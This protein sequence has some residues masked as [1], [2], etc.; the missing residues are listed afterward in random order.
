[1]IR[2]SRYLFTAAL[3]A[4]SGYLIAGETATQAPKMMPSIERGAPAPAEQ[5]VKTTPAPAMKV[6]PMWIWGPDSTKS[7]TLKKEFKGGTKAILRASCDN[8]M[9]V[10]INGDEVGTSSEWAEPLILDIT[11]QLKPENNIIEV[12]VGNAGGI[13][14]F[15]G[16]IHVTDASGVTEIVSDETWVLGTNAK[17]GKTSYAKK[18]ANYGAQP[19]GNVL[20][21]EANA[22]PSANTGMFNVLPGFQVEKLF[23]VPKDKFG[24]WVCMT[25][26]N[27][28][29][30]IA[31][32]QGGLG[33][34]RITPPKVG[35][36][37]ET[38]VEKLDVKMTSAQGLL[39][40]FDSLYVVANGGPG[41]GLYR[42]KDTNNDDQFDE[43]VKLKAFAGGGE[44][45]PH[46]VRLTP[47]GKN[48]FVLAGNHTLP[49]E[50][51]NASRLPSNWSEDHLLPRQ[52]DANGHA[53][54]ILAPGGWVAKT[55]PEGKTWEIFTGGYRNPYDFAINGDGEMFVYDADME[56]DIG[57]PWY[58]PT[59]VNHATSGS[60]LGWRSGTG[61]WPAYYVDSLPAAVDIGP[62][63]PV[64]VEF[65]YGTKFPAKYQK[66]LYILDWTFGTIYAIHTEP[67][68]STY[69][70]TKEE[71]VS[72]TPLPLTDCAVGPDGNFYFTVGGR[73]TQSEL[74][75]VIY[76]GKE[77][78][79]KVDNKNTKLADQRAIRKQLESYHEKVSDPAKAVEFALPYLKSED[80]FMRYAA[81]VALEH[82]QVDLWASKVLAATDADSI[83]LGAVAL[84]HQGPK[85]LQPKILASLQKLEFAKLDE[86]LQL[87]WLR[88]LSL[89][90]LRTGE[91][92]KETAATFVKILDPM[93]PSQ[94]DFVSRE[95]CQVL[96]YLKSPTIIAKTTKLLDGPSK[97]SPNPGLSDL[98][99]RNKGYGAAIQK[100]IDNGADQQKV[101][102]LYY[103]RNAKDGWTLDQRKSYFNAIAEARTKSGGNS[104][105]GFLNNIEKDNF[106]LASEADRLAIEAAGLRKPYKPKEIPKPAGPGKMY[107]MDDILALEG[108]LKGRNFSNGLK[109]FAA[110]QCVQCHRFYGDGGATGPDLTQSAG[111]FSYKDMAEAIIAPSKVISDQYRAYNITTASGKKY[112]GKIVTDTKAQ[113]TVLTDPVDS[114]KVVDIKRADIEEILPSAVSMM[115]EGLFS[116]LNENEVLDLMAYLLSRGDP[117]HPF[118]KK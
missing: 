23:T 47:D 85:D 44:H 94:S 109:M 113:I 2:L 102:Y 62:G 41:S 79:E 46:A 96:T 86:R 37:E 1:M 114:T 40:A 3:L 21:G 60:E 45:G 8:T 14:G 87:D 39:Y 95:L 66:A 34:Y 100:M 63:S 72:R 10:K 98:L 38:K 112:S 61:K 33:L 18:V 7:Y 26:D 64:G 91:P 104:Y 118:F 58:R 52:W 54:G 13:A 24:S 70:A 82:Q 15:V 67:N 42:L 73:G 5:P 115:P 31:S 51:F 83:I 76:T 49:P 12:R 4:V 57:S 71:F 101:T 6:T 90:F 92:D 103:L 99:A 16:H 59:R 117:N 89:V 56:W 80:R 9:T 30:I 29:R 19:W 81:R 108:K 116:T 17:T 50:K 69:S 55:D 22:K 97:A 35:T 110:A 48:I 111:R 105:Q 75:R 78:T 77:S 106:D 74:F 88:A 43:V 27:K 36:T 28:G 53:R 20:S 25:F 68:G 32:D 11:K 84:A 107:K 93:F 65:G